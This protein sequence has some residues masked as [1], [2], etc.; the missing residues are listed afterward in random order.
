MNTAAPPTASPDVDELLRQLNV[1]AFAGRDL[2]E[3]ELRCTRT[4]DDSPIG[5]LCGLFRQ[6][7]ADPAFQVR[8]DGEHP[9]TQQEVHALQGAPLAAADATVAVLLSRS[10]VPDASGDLRLLDGT[11]GEQEHVPSDAPIYQQPQAA[12]ATGVLVAPNL[13]ATAAHVITGYILSDLRFVF[14]FRMAADGS[15]P[16]RLGASQVYPAQG[17]V[18]MHFDPSQ[19]IDWALIMTDRPVVG[20]TPVQLRRSR[21]PARGTPLYLIGHPWGLPSKYTSGGAM[22]MDDDPAY[23][24]AR[25]AVFDH[26]SGS[27]AFSAVDDALEGIYD[28][29]QVGYACI[30]IE[31][32]ARMVVVRV[33]RSPRPRFTRAC[34]FEHLVAPT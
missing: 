31:G 15:P 29:G 33:P 32:G 11:F 30:W 18:G 34:M 14:G 16:T 3:Q 6:A 10:L 21:W 4:V 9:D 23:F 17:V 2:T 26:D 13:I 12:L 19:G 27:P 25:L 28:G 5:R 22:H 7:A 24:H 20:H 1:L 8:I